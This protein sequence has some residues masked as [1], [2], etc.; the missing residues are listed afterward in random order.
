[1]NL[2]HGALPILASS[3]VTVLALAQAPGAPAPNPARAPTAATEN[4]EDLT[5]TTL[6]SPPEAPAPPAEAVRPSGSAPPATSPTNAEPPARSIASPPKAVATPQIA[7]PEEPSVSAGPRNR[8]GFYVRVDN[9]LG[10]AGFSGTGPVG[11]ASL[12]GLGSLSVVAIG[13]SIGRGV[14]LAGTLQ[15]M[16]LTARF[17]GGPFENRYIGVGE[18]SIPSSAKADAVFSQIGLLIDWYPSPLNGWHLGAS[19]GLGLISLVNRADDSTFV[20]TGTGGTIFGGYDWFIAKKWSMGI[21]LIASGV[22]SASLKE[23][24]EGNDAGYRLRGFALGLGG[25][26]LY[27]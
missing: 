24:E 6:S 22:T 16:T 15:A 14:V 11:S 12:E 20:G 26:L 25:S 19:G 7:R 1:M 23:A 4:V 21:S 18:E 9:G 5:S 17:N 27:F 2:L 10:Y 3:T 13:G 8:R